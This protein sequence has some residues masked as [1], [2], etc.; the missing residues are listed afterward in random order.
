[1]W[2]V[3]HFFMLM[4]ITH[5][6]TFPRGKVKQKQYNVLDCMLEVKRVPVMCV[7]MQ[8]A[9]KQINS[10]Q[11]MFLF[12]YQGKKNIRACQA[13]LRSLKKADM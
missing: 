1:M 6:E 11:L 3:L 9:T 2:K 10:S 4:T 7:C 12:Y 5:S 13:I 8:P